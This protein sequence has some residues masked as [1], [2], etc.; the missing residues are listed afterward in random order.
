MV[1]HRICALRVNASPLRTIEGEIKVSPFRSVVQLLRTK[2]RSCVLATVCV[3]ADQPL[4][5]NEIQHIYQCA[6]C[7]V[8]LGPVRYKLVGSESM[9]YTKH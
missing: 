2:G 4:K 8:T 7:C 6:Y 3:I 5:A 9:I 1:V